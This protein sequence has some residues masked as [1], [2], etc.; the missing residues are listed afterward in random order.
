MLIDYL[1]AHFALLFHATK[2]CYHKD[3][4]LRQVIKSLVNNLSQKENLI[5]WED[6]ILFYL[7]EGISII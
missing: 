4:L 1:D 6:K 3:W 7:K 2:R 5:F